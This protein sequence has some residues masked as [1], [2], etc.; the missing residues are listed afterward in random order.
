MVALPLDRRAIGR[1]QNGVHFRGLQIARR[2]DR[3][4]LYGHVQ[5]LGALLDSRRLTISHEAEKLRNA[6]RRQLRVPIVSPR[7]CSVYYRKALTSKAV[8][9]PSVS[10]A[11]GRSQ[12]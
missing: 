4:F 11:A 1:G 8:R 3:C 9:S 12:R 10:W 7:S 6:D 2:V 5:N